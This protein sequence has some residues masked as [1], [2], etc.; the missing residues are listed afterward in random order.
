MYADAVNEIAKHAVNGHV[1]YPVEMPPAQDLWYK[2]ENP[3]D[4]VMGKAWCLFF[5]ISTDFRSGRR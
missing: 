3:I 2:G 5:E 1:K 4:L